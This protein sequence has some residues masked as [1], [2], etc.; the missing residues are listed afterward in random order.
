M[1][2]PG[3]PD[4]SFIVHLTGTKGDRL[5]INSIPGRPAQGL[6]GT[7]NVYDLPDDVYYAD[8]SSFL[9]SWTLTLTPS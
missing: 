7:D 5:L 4:C 6:S 8:V 3:E 2:D 9:C 1:L